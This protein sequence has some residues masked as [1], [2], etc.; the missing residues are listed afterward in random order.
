MLK[1]AVILLLLVLGL[2]LLLAQ[3]A[4]YGSIK[5]EA[6][7]FYAEGSFALAHEAYEKA[8]HLKLSLE[9][10][11]WVEFRL[12]DT[13]WRAQSATDNPDT[14]RLDNA[15]QQLEKMVA[16][17]TRTQDQDQL[18]AEAQESLGD[19]WWIRRDSADWGQAWTHYEAAL[20]FWAGS[21]HIDLARGRYLAI[22]WKAARP[23]SPVPYYNQYGENL[24]PLNVLENALK[25]SSS[26]KDIAYLHYL[27]AV[28]LLRQG[29]PV[30]QQKAPAEF[31]SA[32]QAGKQC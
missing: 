3:P 5:S 15:R 28:S 21:Q 18:W 24:L 19:Y 12:A 27:V 7:K 1:I 25:I 17:R 11:R 14:T 2:G 32:I 8:S 10:A 9:E 30:Q 22:V 13:E 16:D 23:K 20:N 4:D 6:E 29:D 26:S 31:E